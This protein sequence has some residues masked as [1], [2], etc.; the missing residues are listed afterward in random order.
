MVPQ[1]VGGGAVWGWPWGD[2]VSQSPPGSGPAGLFGYSAR[3]M[4]PPPPICSLSRGHRPLLVSVPHA[5]RYLPG[6]IASRLVAA[7]DELPDTDH[8]VDQIYAFVRDMGASLLVAHWSRWVVDLNRPADDT[9]LYAGQATTGLVPQARFD[10]APIWQ[11]G[12]EPDAAEV[13][14]RKT[15]GWAPYHEALEAELQ[16]LKAIHGHV[17]LWDGH[18]ILSRVPRL[19][20]GTLPDLNL[21]TNNG[22]SCAPALRQLV[23]E[24]LAGLSPWSSVVD[25]RF[26]GGHITRHYGRPDDAVHALQLELA[27]ST[28]MDEAAETPVWDPVRAR[29]LME[30][31]A[32]ILDEVAA[33]RP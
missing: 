8:F 17:V 1:C 16:R 30:A 11:S 22:A 28:Y 6:D 12:G 5:G 14:R 9:P 15:L 3:M 2:S 26:R 32:P 21:G 18:S 27:Q 25:G 10:G 4:N 29:P 33:W 24:R 7:P 13:R 19:F 23:A 31:L 20:D